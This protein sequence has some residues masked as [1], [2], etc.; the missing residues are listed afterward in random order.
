MVS[1]E[2]C[3]ACLDLDRPWNKEHW[4]YVYVGLLCGKANCYGKHSP[5]SAGGVCSEDRLLYCTAKSAVTAFSLSFTFHVDGK[6]LIG[7]VSVRKGTSQN[8]LFLGK[9]R[10]ERLQ[11]R[12]DPAGSW[13][14]SGGKATRLNLEKR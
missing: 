1:V 6:I 2:S 14:I 11:M 13:D 10:Q 5:S 9:R 7:I 8:L 12:L 3:T 4:G